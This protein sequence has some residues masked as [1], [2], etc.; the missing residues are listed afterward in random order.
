M[1]KKIT[2][3]LFVS[4]AVF[5]TADAAPQT[6]PRPLKAC[7]EFLPYGVPT[8][9]K[10]D[11]IKICRTAYML[12]YDKNAKV[13]SWVAYSLTP[14][15]TLGCAPRV[16]AFAA[17]QSLPKAHRA[18][19]QD[20]AGSGYDTGHLANN[21]DMSWSADVARESFILSNMAPQL[22]SVNRGLWKQ[23]ESATRAWAFARNNGVTIYTGSIYDLKK[24]KRIGDNQVIV[25]NSF[26]KIVVD[27]DKKIS[28]A[29]IF[30]HRNDLGNDLRSVQ[31]TVA[32]I[33]QQTGI[34]FP[35]PDNRNSRN[36]LWSFDLKPI[37][38]AKR[39]ACGS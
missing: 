21:A 26:Y 14:K 35:I 25:P 19:V 29:F 9:N 4:L 36:P 10:A 15:Q 32:A 13:A 30:P 16:N 12:Q 11:Q 22:P 34:R 6:P 1:L 23:L 28:L 33:E 20:Y 37:T 27:N 3:S 39:S 17:D 24:D 8:S 2:L 7:D 31:T 18:E 5:S 38:A